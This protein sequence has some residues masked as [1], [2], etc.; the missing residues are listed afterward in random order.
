[1][2]RESHEVV[3]KAVKAASQ[4]NVDITD[5]TIEELQTIS[6]LISKEMVGLLSPEQALESRNHIGG[7]GSQAVMSAISNARKLIA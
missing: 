3:A 6:P 4:Q 2:S 1:R 7:T 5:L